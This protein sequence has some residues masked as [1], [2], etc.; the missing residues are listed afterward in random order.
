MKRFE[1]LFLQSFK[2]TISA[3][4]EPQQFAFRTKRFTE[5]AR[6]KLVSLLSTLFLDSVEINSYIG[7]L[8]DFRS[9]FNSMSS[10]NWWQNMIVQH[11]IHNNIYW[12]S[13][14]IRLGQIRFTVASPPLWYSTPEPP[15]SGLCSIPFCLL[16]TPIT[17]SNKTWGNLFCKVWQ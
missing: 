14:K 12:T 15:P 9:P 17:V 6:F 8:R 3:S 11:F 16:C 7:M 5:E 13:T 4:L 1:K 10:K 2:D